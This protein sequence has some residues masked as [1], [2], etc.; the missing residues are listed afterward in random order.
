M[1]TKEGTGIV[2]WTNEPKPEVREK[3]KRIYRRH[4]WGFKGGT[5]LLSA[6]FILQLLAEWM[7]P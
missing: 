3:N 1:V 2:G 5:I 4:Q 6:G 7:R